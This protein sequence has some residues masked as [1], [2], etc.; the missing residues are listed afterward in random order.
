MLEM[1]RPKKLGER[2]TASSTDTKHTCAHDTSDLPV[3]LSVNQSEGENLASL[4]GNPAQQLS[5]DANLLQTDDRD[6]VMRA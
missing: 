3:T 1:Q 4:S 6:E 2:E 5:A